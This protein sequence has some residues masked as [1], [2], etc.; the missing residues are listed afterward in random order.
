MSPRFYSLAIASS[1]AT[2]LSA[3][4][5]LRLLRN[6]E[7]LDVPNA[8]SS[9]SVV[10]PRGGGLA[11]ATG[12]LAGSV[13]S[14]YDGKS[15]PAAILVPTL[16]LAVL[17]FAD[18]KVGL[19]ASAR[20]S[21]QGAIGIAAGS[22]K[23][24]AK[25]ALIGGVLF[26]VLVNA[27]NFMDGI[28]GMTSS[29]LAAWGVCGCWGHSEIGER[30]VF[31]P[32]SLAL[33]SSLGFL[34]WNVPDAKMFLGDV[35]SYLFGGLVA[36]AVLLEA[37][38]GRSVTRAISTLSPLSLYFADT[39]FALLGKVVRRQPLTGA[40]RNHVYQRLADLPHVEHWQVSACFE[41]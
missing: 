38:D 37:V 11:C 41:I 6:Q 19:P 32:A 5:V 24:G 8:R 7:M 40:H 15:V 13:V 39:G 34:P 23:G 35:G 20:F 10:T 18:D 2:V 21:A 33:G 22:S 29:T 12:I 14:A 25:G 3:P 4:L 16:S 36:S 28:N 30:R 26:P 31:V 17:G 27:V 1:C 9:H